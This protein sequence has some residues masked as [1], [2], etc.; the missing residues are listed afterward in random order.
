[1]AEGATLGKAWVQIVPSAKGISGSIS[2]LLDGEATSAGISAG[3]AVGSSMVDTIKGVIAA[4]GIGAAIKSSVTAGMNFDSEMAKVSAISGATGSAFDTL[5]AKALELGSSTKFSASESASAFKYMAMAG[6]NVEQM[7]SGVD[8]V[9][10]LAAADGLDLATTSDIVTDALTGF[11]LEAKDAGHFAD[12]LA[13]A[14]SSA[15]TNVAMMGETFKYASAVVGSLYGNGEQ[16]TKGMEDAALA[17]GLMANAGVKSTQAGTAFRAILTRIATN[18]GETKT[19]MGALSILTKKLG[20]EFYDES[21][22]A[23]NFSDVLRECRAAWSDLSVEE[24]AS[25]AKIIAGQEAMSGW[26]A[27]MNASEE[28]VNDLANAIENADGTAERMA[29][30]MQNT[31]DGARTSFLS[32]VEGLQ[33]AVYDKFSASITDMVNLARDGVSMITGVVTTGDWTPLKEFGNSLFQNVLSG[34]MEGVPSLA[35]GAA[36]MAPSVAEGLRAGIPAAVESAAGVVKSLAAVVGENAPTFVSAGLTVIRGLAD[37]VLRG[38]PTF[39]DTASSLALGFAESVQENLPAVADAALNIAGQFASFLAEGLRT[40]IPAAASAVAGLAESLASF[41]LKNIPALLDSGLNIV[42]GLADGIL[43]SL[44]VLTQSAFSLVSSFAQSVRENLPT[45]LDAALDIAQQFVSFLAEN[46]VTAIPAAASGVADFAQYLAGVLLENAPRLI[47]SG[48]ELAQAVVTG[49]INGLPALAEAAVNLMASFGAFIRDNLPSLLQSGLEM[50]TQL[51]GS[52]RENAGKLVDGGIELLKNLA[53][54]FADSIPIL[55]ENIPTIVSNIAGIINDNAPKI[56]A[57]GVSIIFTLAKGIIQ[58][59]PTLIAEFP[60]IIKAIFDVWNAVNW[61][62]LGTKLI[63]LIGNGIKSLVTNIPNLIKGIA[64]TAGNVIK[65]FGWASF[66]RGVIISIGQGVQSLVTAIPTALKNIAVTA[67]NWFKSGGWLKA[68]QDIINGLI[69]GIVGMGASAVEAIKN[70]GIEILDGIKS[71]FGIHSPS[72]VFANIGENLIGGLLQGISGAWKSV[73]GFFSNRVE[74]ITGAF[75]GLKDRLQTIGGNI[76]G[77]LR[78][79][80]SSAWEGA[81]GLGNWFRDKIDSLKTAAME[82]LDEH[83]PSKVF[84]EIGQ[85]VS[86]GLRDGINNA[87]GQTIVA[88][89]DIAES[90]KETIAPVSNWAVRVGEEV[91]IGLASGIEEELSETAKAAKDAAD[92]ISSNIYSGL[93]KWAD[94]TAKFERLSLSDQ[95][96]MWTEI[97]KQFSVNSERWWNIEEKLFDLRESVIK[98]SYDNMANAIARSVKRENLSLSEQLAAWEGVM[99]RFSVGS[100]QWAAAEEK[101]YDLRVQLQEEFVNK[102]KSAAETISG[103]QE[104]Y[105]KQV[106]E[107][108]KAIAGSYKLFDAVPEKEQVNASELTKNLQ[109]QIKSIRSF[110]DNLSELSARGVGDSLVEEI[111]GMGVGASGE[112]AALLSMSDRQLSRYADLYEEKQSLANSVALRELDSLGE[113]TASRIQEQMDK[114][115]VLY[116]ENAPLVGTTFA[117]GVAEGI[118]G[119]MFDIMSAAVEATQ[120]AVDSA[121]EILSVQPE[122]LKTISQISSGQ[123]DLRRQVGKDRYYSLAKTQERTNE[124]TQLSQSLRG[125]NKMQINVP[126]YIDGQ[127]FARASYNSTAEEAR[128]RG[129]SFV[130]T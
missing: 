41:I 42:Q 115:K 120:G 1:M 95:L 2:K 32:A 119:G 27:M 128:R 73:T 35:A 93:S 99:S 45:L 104:D 59:I 113:E 84:A 25:N 107:R 79:G 47:D 21:G 103:L 49:V 52:V 46:L 20:V 24:Q 17:I 9:L 60:K 100:E 71:L 34:I 58:S 89:Q 63:T 76:I 83:S 82:Q 122:T 6:W 112:L 10:S 109:G 62:S 116:D 126:L 22:K 123:Y 87:S 111:R 16:A 44:P 77:G 108:A 85:Y 102:F 74:D 88:V 105:Q 13:V 101:A 129:P 117:E 48:L 38:L 5:R 98:E 51:S 50:V 81:K 55:I 19:Q 53:Q 67:I 30:I 11:G 26:L 97:Q 86:L 37:G 39:I 125:Q 15:N 7:M 31:L 36:Q 65:N 127:R 90:L 18:A 72:T 23:R 94:R 14:S 80:I 68:G 3:T 75:S 69:S 118:R 56:L 8:G 54:G 70:I 43:Q 106:S 78:Q 124:G 61:L 66:G 130:K 110:Y 12:V 29:E 121:K 57:A 64:E 40:G 114:L 96:S 92:K 4:A 91:S 28:S 33:I